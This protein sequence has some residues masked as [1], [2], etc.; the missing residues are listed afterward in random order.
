MA[1]KQWADGWGKMPKSKRKA[2]QRSAFRL[3]LRFCAVLTCFGFHRR[4]PVARG[5]ALPPVHPAG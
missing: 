4:S 3:L 1:L 5:S 2:E